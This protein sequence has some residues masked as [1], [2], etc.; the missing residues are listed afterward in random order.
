MSVPAVAVN[1]K[2]PVDP[3]PAADAFVPPTIAAPAAPPVSPVPVTVPPD[4]QL[5]QAEEEKKNALQE[6]EKKEKAIVDAVQRK[7]NPVVN[8]VMNALTLARNNTVKIT[9]ETPLCKPE[10]ILARVM[11][12]MTDV[13]N[14]DIDKAYLLEFLS[15]DMCLNL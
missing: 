14:T 13:K 7:S 6:I 10:P 15:P 3:V 8:P 2:P 12:V 5:V 4:A 11:H 1:L 9:P